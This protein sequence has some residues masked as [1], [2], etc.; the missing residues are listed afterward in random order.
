MNSTDRTSCFWLETIPRTAYI[1]D[2]RFTSMYNSLKWSIFE[3]YFGDILLFFS[4]FL[5]QAVQCL[6]ETP[7]DVNFL[8]HFLQS[9]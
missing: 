2:S 5:E 9:W 7:L 6:V 3:W 4:V 1:L 8:P